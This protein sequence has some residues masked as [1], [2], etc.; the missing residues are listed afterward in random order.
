MFTQLN[1][2][3][4]THWGWLTYFWTIVYYNL[5]T[6]N[7]NCAQ[8]LDWISYLQKKKIESK[9]KPKSHQ[10]QTPIAT[11]VKKFKSNHS[12][13][14]VDTPLQSDYL[15]LKYSDICILIFFVIFIFSFNDLMNQNETS[16]QQQRSNKK[17]F[18]KKNQS[19]FT[20]KGT[21]VIQK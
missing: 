19:S 3:A 2:R 18:L 11:E 5:L 4:C 12:K 13:F 15:Q 20:W 14:P 1:T 9:L 6:I 16:F 17:H 7:K 21:N 10:P 8:E